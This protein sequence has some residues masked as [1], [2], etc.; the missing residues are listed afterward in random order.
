MAGAAEEDTHGDG[1]ERAKEQKLLAA[2]LDEE[3]TSNK[4]A[5]ESDSSDQKAWLSAE[6]AQKQAEAIEAARQ[7]AMEREEEARKV[8]PGSSL[9][10]VPCVRR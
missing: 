3:E 10:R 5:A 7:Q 1:A 6:A 4:V 9:W 8:R 2:G